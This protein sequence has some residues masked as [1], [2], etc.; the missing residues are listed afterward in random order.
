LLLPAPDIPVTMTKWRAAPRA[1]SIWVTGSRRFELNALV[2]LAIGVAGPR[3]HC[4]RGRRSSRRKS[5]E[6]KIFR[7]E[8]ANALLPIIRP[9]LEQL[10]H[11]RRDHA[12]AQLEADVA[13][14]FELEE[15]GGTRALV[16]EDQSRALRDE[17]LSLIERVQRHGCIVKD[18]D[19]GLVDFPALRGGQ[20]VNLCWKLDEPQVAFWHATDEGFSARKSLARRR[21]A[22]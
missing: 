21:D 5:R 3:S 11:R 15:A 22:K 19:L 12:I 4:V 2:V 13:R 9:I 10:V 17:M 6:M 14:N 18:I 16:R 8:E 20:L 7:L 1:A